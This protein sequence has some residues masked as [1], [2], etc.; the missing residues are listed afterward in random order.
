M[1]KVRMVQSQLLTSRI[2]RQRAD[3]LAL[4]RNESRAE[5]WRKAIEGGGIAQMEQEHLQG[6]IELHDLAARFGFA[7]GGLELAEQMM[8][9]GVTLTEARKLSEYPLTAASTSA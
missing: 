2:T 5:I 8:K 4:I 9:E 6:L 3:A 7:G 1:H